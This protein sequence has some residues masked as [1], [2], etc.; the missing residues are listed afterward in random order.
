[1]AVKTPTR[2]ARELDGVVALDACLLESLKDRQCERSAHDVL[3]AAD[4][5]LAGKTRGLALEAVK[6]VVDEARDNTVPAKRP[7]VGS[8]RDPLRP[9]IALLAATRANG[10]PSRTRVNAQ[11]LGVEAES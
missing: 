9:T 8:V 4:G 7:A 1:M 6:G 11:W 5:R 10:F 3:A 2:V